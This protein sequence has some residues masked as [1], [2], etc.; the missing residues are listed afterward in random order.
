MRADVLR[1]RVGKHRAGGAEHER[2]EDERPV[3]FGTV[4]EREE[5]GR[6]DAHALAEEDD[7]LR[8]DYA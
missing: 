4:G 2:G 5:D 8:V 7:P 1:V 3:A 6:D